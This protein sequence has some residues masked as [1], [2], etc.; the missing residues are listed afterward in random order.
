MEIVKQIMEE[1][2]KIYACSIRKYQMPRI[3]LKIDLYMENYKT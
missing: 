1:K 2:L 3:N